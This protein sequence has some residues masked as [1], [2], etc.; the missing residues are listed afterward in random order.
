M[1]SV[2]LVRNENFRTDNARDPW[3]ESELPD[4]YMTMI[5]TAET[6]ADR[7]EISRERQDEYALQS[8]LRTAL[9]Q[10]NGLMDDEIV[11]MKS[12]M[13]YFDR[14]NKTET[15]HEVNLM[16]DEGNRPDTSLEG[17]LALKPVFKDGI[18]I[19]EGSYITAGNASQ[20]SDGASASILMESKDCLLY[21][22]PS[23]RDATLSRMPSSA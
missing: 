4:L 5:E 12:T 8:Q 16:K 19:N 1:E 2:S 10:R 15:F 6:V 3:L 11:P 9:A 14:E 13:K 17:L 22:S 23:P 18:H 20:L 7:Y 21:T